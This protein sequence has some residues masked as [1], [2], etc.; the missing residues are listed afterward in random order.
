MAI[1][2]YGATLEDADGS[3]G[4]FIANAPKE[5]KELLK[6]AVQSTTFAVLQRMQAT[7]P[8]GPDAPHIKEDLAYAV[9]GLNG[10]A[11]ILKGTGEGDS[12]HIAL[13][14]EYI[15]NK[16]PFMR[17]AAKAEEG[18]FVR[19]TLEALGQLERRLGS[20]TGF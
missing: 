4:R 20:G 14:N 12:A 13:Y 11:G 18:A 15:P 7:V 6:S 16:Q 1:R 8:V 10:R 17:P 19:R 9:R 2:K 5:C 3:F